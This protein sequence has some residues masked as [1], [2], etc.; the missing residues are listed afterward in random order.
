MEGIAIE[1]SLSLKDGPK[2]SPLDKEI[3]SLVLT[4]LSKFRLKEEELKR[5][6]ERLYEERAAFEEEKSVERERFR[7][8]IS[9]EYD[10]LENERAKLKEQVEQDTQEMTKYLTEL[11]RS[12]EVKLQRLE[13]ERTNI[14][15]IQD[16][17]KSKIKLDIG[18][19]IFSCSRSTL[20]KYEDS[21][22]AA[23]F[24]GRHELVKGEDGTYF[25]DRDGTYFRY[26]LNFLRDGI[27]VNADLPESKTALREIRRESDYYQL[28]LLTNIIDELLSAPPESPDFSQ[29]EINE[30]LSTV[31]RIEKP[32]SSGLQNNAF[33]IRNPQFQPPIPQWAQAALLQQQQQDNPSDNSAN[34]VS[35]NMTKKKLDFSHKN[36][37]GISFAHTTFN[38][39][40]SFKNSKLVGATF[41]GC[42]F[43]VGVIIDFSKADLRDCDFRNCKGKEAGPKM[44]FGPSTFEFGGGGLMSG[45]SSDIFLRLINDKRIIF[46]GARMDGV[47]FDPN[48]IHFI[49]QMSK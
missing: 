43:G 17:Q 32:L 28:H 33:Q 8:E 44:S 9:Q 1:A 19:H 5:M 12:Y 14:K 31:V 18:G 22:L 40:V 6:K 35:Q 29:D 39:D 2:S 48:V 47:K 36:L 38:H 10:K 42:E 20:C 41:Y 45:A 26:I 4:L 49:K 27:T 46:K 7:I 11:Q 16:G 23:M 15:D 37:V 30:I 34:F 24:S 25:I 3:Q 13:E 21:M